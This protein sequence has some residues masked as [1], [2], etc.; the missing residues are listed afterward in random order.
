MYAPVR[1]RI[2]V[3]SSEYFLPTLRDIPA[4]AELISHQLLL[5]AGYIRKLSAGVYTFLPLGWRVIRKIDQIIREEMDK[6]P[7][8]ELRMPTLHPREMLE[9][10]GRWNVDV[11]YKLKDRR[12][13]DLALGFT[14]EEVMA[15]IAR[16]DLRSWRDLP[17]QLYQIQTKFRDEPRPRGG[18]IRTREFI[19]FDAYTFD[20]DE[21]GMDVAYHKQWDAY[22][23]IYKRMGLPYLIVEADGGAI[24]D[25]DN[26]EFMTLS[27]A[28]EDTVLR[29]PGCNYAANAERCAV[30]A[31]PVIEA[32][33]GGEKPLELVS[34]PAARTVAE[35]AGM[36]G[37]TES[38]LVKTLLFLADGMP[39]AV[40]VRGDRDVNEIKLK[41]L[42]KANDLQMA[43]PETVERLTG[44]P[45]GFAGPT[46]LNEV[47]ILADN[48]VRGMRNFITG[49]N[50]AD[51]HYVH[52]NIGRDFEVSEYADIRVAQAG[53][54]CPKCQDAKLEDA[55]GIEVGHIFKLGE[56]YSGAM[57]ANYADA[58]GT[59][60]PI[61]MGSYGIGISRILAALIEVSH[62]AD[63]IIWHPEVAPFQVSIVVANT[64]DEA[65]MAAG[66][67]LHDELTARGIEVLLDDREERAGV[68]FKDADLIGFPVRV[69]VGKG[70]ANG[71]LEVRARKDAST[72]RE[73]PVAE[74]A[75]A[76]ADLLEALKAA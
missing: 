71:V 10:T 49:A 4:E 56:K 46:G 68:K 66:L 76:V 27:E 55:R 67:A 74:A 18:V 6:I 22:E 16:R 63:G 26:H 19:M 38:N 45:V 41:R 25:L 62:D 30:I 54:L 8:M 58:E 39:V 17:L 72:A 51:A 12:D 3:K 7:C 47:R 70:L 36:L 1:S 44:A 52:V 13:A 64:K 2:F 31:P 53:D 61:Q 73:V 14:H 50:Q 9:E 37:T 24:G 42:L 57:G 21:E 23:R 28:G 15:D 34:T 40:L 43:G 59:Q 11:V 35:V 60:R 65:A 32:T 20:R 5:R 29:C 33:P 75:Q 48:E 69:V